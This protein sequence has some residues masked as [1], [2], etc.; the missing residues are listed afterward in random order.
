[1]NNL[2]HLYYQ[3]ILEEFDQYVLE[4]PDFILQIPDQAQ[5]IFGQK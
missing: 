4:H 2:Y 5:L 3:E 1:M